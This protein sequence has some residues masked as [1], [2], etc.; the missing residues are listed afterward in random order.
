LSG[1]APSKNLSAWYVEPLWRLSYDACYRRAWV[2]E[3]M[4]DDG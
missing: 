4:Q 2:R 3:Q 1:H